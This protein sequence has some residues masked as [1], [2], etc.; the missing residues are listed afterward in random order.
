MAVP[1]SENTPKAQRQDRYSAINAPNSGPAEGGDAPDR[2]HD[3][4]ELRPDGAWKQPLDRDEG[5]RHQRA[6]AKPLDQAPDQ[7]HRH[8]RRMP[9]RSARRRHRAG[10]RPPCWCAAARSSPAVRRQRRRRS[11]R[12][13]RSAAT[14]R[15]ARRRQSSPTMA[16]MTVATMVSLV[17][18][19]RMPRLMKQKR[20]RSPLAH[21]ARQSTLFGCV[22]D[23]L[24]LPNVLIRLQMVERSSSSNRVRGASGTVVKPQPQ[25]SSSG[26]CECA[27][28]LMTG[29]MSRWRSWRRAMIF[30]WHGGSHESR[31]ASEQSCSSSAPHAELRDG[32]HLTEC[33]QFAVR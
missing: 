32:A 26:F 14:S 13:R 7:E 24:A 21:S 8:G 25:L 4:E 22:S 12:A 28:G 19:S 6:A 30:R 23:H 20:N 33:A 11:R 9:R 18:C 17:A 1:P 29:G 31:A 16:G 2:R 3:A 27:E 10:R 5:Q 15:P